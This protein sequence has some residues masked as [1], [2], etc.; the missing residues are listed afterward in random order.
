MAQPVHLLDLFKDLDNFADRVDELDFAAGDVFNKVTMRVLLGAE[1]RLGHELYSLAGFRDALRVVKHF[2]QS[3]VAL[4]HR[5]IKLKVDVTLDDGVSINSD[6]VKLRVVAQT[7]LEGNRATTA[8]IVRLVD[9]FR[10]IVELLGGC[11]LEEIDQLRTLG[12]PAAT[13]QLRL[14]RACRLTELLT[15]SK[16]FKCLSIE[17]LAESE[18]FRVD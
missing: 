17:V 2:V 5:T 16:V 12:V 14:S 18:V 1:H 6:E 13:Q 10:G 8:F 9:V 11:V 7:Q 3:Q 4:A 15:C